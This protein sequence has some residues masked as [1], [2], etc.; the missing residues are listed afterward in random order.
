MRDFFVLTFFETLPWSRALGELRAALA[1]KDRE[2]ALGA[3]RALYRALLEQEASDLLTAAAEALLWQDSSF[4]RAARQHQDLPRGLRQAA[5]LDLEALLTQLGRD[6]AQETSRVLGHSVP[7]LAE[8]AAPSAHPLVLELAAAL[9]QGDASWLLGHLQNAYREH[10]SGPLARFDAFR[11]AGG[12]LVGIRHPV[13]AD[14]NRLV[15]LERPLTL[16]KQN[17]LAFLSGKPAQ[18]TLLYGPRGSGKSTAV[19]S[20]I[21]HFA[22]AGLRLIE[23]APTDLTALPEVIAPLRES[24]H[25]FILF[26]DD[27]SFE[28]GDSSY[29]P[30]KSLLEGSLTERPENVLI[31][32]TSNR[33]HLV[34]EQFKD[35]PDP[36][37]DDVHA[38]DTHNERLA[39][40]D[41]FGL[42][43]TFP[44]ATQQ[45]YLEVVRGLAAQEGLEA[46]D[47][48][49]RAIRFAEWGNG[50]S[51]RTAQQFVDALK[52]GQA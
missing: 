6:W 35:R 14:M 29:Q 23:L 40:A 34:K 3:Y 1:I 17:T 7:T 48:S 20:L 42:V 18:H 5:L 28:S 12:A 15:G 10:G 24:P 52:A 37:D 36:L 11:W 41:R 27:F 44:S 4:S 2:A 39:L 19:R 21:K 8:L 32:A 16:L 50:Y 47:L 45:R 46:R 31:Y 38:W 51:G 30:L 25:R 26:V 22:A 9:R 49:E 43:I 13:Q 33:R